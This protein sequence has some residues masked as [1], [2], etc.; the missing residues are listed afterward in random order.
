MLAMRSLLAER[1]KLK[2]HKETREMDVYALVMVK[3]GVPGPALKQSS[4]DCL[5]MANAQ[6]RFPDRVLGR[7]AFITIPGDRRVARLPTDVPDRWTSPSTARARRSSPCS[8][9][10]SLARQVSSALLSR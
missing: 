8:Q 7:Q 1:F 9:H 4:T 2:L 3:P 5:A 10:E 6:S